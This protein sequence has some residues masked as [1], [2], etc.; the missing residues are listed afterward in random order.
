M[1]IIHLICDGRIL[2]LVK[3]QIVTTGSENED[4]IVF[5]FSDD[6]NGYKKTA[7]F[8]ADGRSY[9]VLLDEDNT[10]TI[11]TEAI[12]ERGKIKIGV[13]GVNDIAVKTSTLLQYMIVEGALSLENPISEPTPDIYTQL[14]REIGALGDE[15]DDIKDQGRAGFSAGEGIEFTTLEDGTVE[16]SATAK[17]GTEITIDS[18]LSDAS[19]NPVQNKVVKSAI[20][21]LDTKTKTSLEEITV[22]ITEIDKNFDEVAEEF[23]EIGLTLDGKANNANAILTGSISHNRKAG[24]TVGTNSVAEGN[25]NEASGITSHAEGDNTVAKGKY[26]HAEGRSATTASGDTAHAEGIATTASGEASHSEGLATKA[27]GNEQHVQ[28]KYNIVDAEGAN[29]KYAHI[30]G[31]GTSGAARS[32]AHTLDWNGNAWFASEVFV[33]GIGQDD[34][35]AEK[36]A[37]TSELT[38]YQ[39][40]LTAGENITIENNTISAAVLKGEKGDTGADGTSVTVSSVTESTG[41]GGSNVVTF[42]DGKTLTVKNGSK[43]STGEKGDAGYTPV[44]GTDYFTEADKTELIDDDFSTTS[45]NALQNKVITSRFDEWDDFIDKDLIPWLEK[46]EESITLKEP[47]LSDEQKA[48]INNKSLQ[49]GGIFASIPFD[50]A[51]E[52]DFIVLQYLLNGMSWTNRIRLGETLDWSTF[53]R[54]SD[55]SETEAI[56]TI[57]CTIDKQEIINELAA[58]LNTAIVTIDDNNAISVVGNLAD[59]T[60]T[61][62]YRN[63]DGTTSYVGSLVIGDG[64]GGG[65]SSP[66]LTGLSVVYD[67][68]TAVEAGTELSALNETVYGV[69]SD[70]SQTSALTENTDFE[71]S[72]TLTAG[73]TNTITVTGKGT[74]A[75]FSA[76]FNVTVAEEATTPSLNLVPTAGDFSNVNNVFN[77]TGYMDGAYAS[78]SSPYYG[79]DTAYVTTGF[80]PAKSNDVFYIKGITVNTAG[81]H[82]RVNIL[83]TGGRTPPNVSSSI[84]KNIDSLKTSGY[85][86]AFETLGDKYYKLTLGNVATIL[87]LSFWDT[88]GGIS[89]SGQGVGANLIVSKTPIE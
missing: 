24:T 3:N 21:A 58:Q 22:Q 31:N 69:Y 70:G 56:T 23:E 32:N 53:I 6:W 48:V 76:T 27:V 65:G 67:N 41:D 61:V 74:Y 11:P 86:S 14:L 33:G 84:C 83:Y 81:G 75:G 30:V 47:L 9:Y 62:S 2:K 79:S 28:G 87:S 85:I 19:E 82:D 15:I 18:E 12:R 37:K 43:G 55:N 52:E 80:I 51:E 72:G 25:N 77:T 26:S 35:S 60:Y 8:Q 59:G 49:R 40:K 1:T 54:N 29:G 42:S 4:K 16:I 7:V 44:K 71:L 38:A 20:D 34:A 46:T 10:A 39:P 68:S 89:I 13:F 63:T 88:Y 45:T 66:T 5:T 36:L 17:G 50:K 73:Q 78:S 64:D 57:N